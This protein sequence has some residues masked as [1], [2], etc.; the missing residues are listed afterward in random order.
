MCFIFYLCYIILDCVTLYSGTL[1]ANSSVCQKY[2]DQNAFF[3]I[4]VASLN[5][6]A[7]EH[8]PPQILDTNKGIYVQ[9]T[10]HIE[11][12]NYSIIMVSLLTIIDIV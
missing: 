12:D 6:V 8:N 3:S 5:P 2:L 1:V 11:M 10:M 9:V 4:V 7:E